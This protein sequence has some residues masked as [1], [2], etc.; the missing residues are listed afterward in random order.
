MAKKSQL[1]RE[2]NRKEL[3]TRHAAKRAELKK[4]IIDPNI[5]EDERR[6]AVFALTKMPR[7][8]SPTRYTR[9]CQRT[10]VSRAVYRKFMLNR[11]SFRDLAL[12]GQLPGVT[13]ASW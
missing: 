5:D 13:K 4:K 6:E 3:A 8:G 12:D 7:D 10:G 1:A 2:R 9:R 11:I